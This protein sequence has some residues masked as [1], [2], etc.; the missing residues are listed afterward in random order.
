LIGAAGDLEAIDLEI[1]LELEQRRSRSRS[2]RD[3]ALVEI[4]PE[5]EQR[6][7]ALG[8]RHLLL[9]EG[10]ELRLHLVSRLLLRAASLA[11]ARQPSL[12]QPQVLAV[13]LAPLPMELT[14]RERTLRPRADLHE[15]RRGQAFRLAPC[16]LVALRLT[17]AAADAADGCQLFG[18]SQ[19]THVFRPF[20]GRDA[21]F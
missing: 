11:V 20:P 1:A 5:L 16:H 21:E 3:R 14:Q 4:A 2:R 6:R 8:P 12:P 17:V 7:S 9:R 15:K 18:E 13:S 19:H 10:V